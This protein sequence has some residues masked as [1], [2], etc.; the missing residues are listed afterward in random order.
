MFKSPGR[1]CLVLLLTVAVGA[2]ASEGS[3]AALLSKMARSLAETPQ[4]SVSMSSRYDAVQ[5][6]GQS[7]EFA[8]LRQLTLRRPDGLRV[9]VQQSDGDKAGLVFDGKL[10]SQYNA[11]EAVYSAMQHSGNV[12]SAIH[13]VVSTLGVRFPLARLLVSS[14][15][16]EI[17]QLTE[18]V[19]FVQRVVLRGVTVDHIAGRGKDVDY[20]AWI[21]ENGLPLRIVLTYKN[22]PGLPRFSADF[23]KWNTRPAIDAGTFEFVPPPGAERILTIVPAARASALSVEKEV[24]QP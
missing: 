14:F 3:G 10:I 16:R 21:S 19:D 6:N 22:A 2:G 23:S 1:W 7:I 8:E 24:D 4:F 15:P 5:P 9:S 12:D 13:F 20:Q 18:Q 11:N 17:E